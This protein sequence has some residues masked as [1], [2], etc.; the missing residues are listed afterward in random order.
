M[1]AFVVGNAVLDETILIA[2]VLQPGASILGQQISRDLGGK[3]ANQAV[4]LGRAGVETVL[5]AAVGQDA[6]SAEIRARLDQE[7]LDLRLIGV[8]VASSDF[9]IVLTSAGGE[10]AIVTTHDAAAALLPDVAVAAIS[11]AA[12][13]DL[14]VLQGNLTEATTRALLAAARLRKMTS[15]VNPSPLRPYFGGLWELVDMAF[16]NEIEAGALGHA[17]GIAAARVLSGPRAVPVVLTLGAQGAVLVVTGQDAISVA[18]APCNVVD[19]T[20]AGDCF[21]ATAI[22][23]ASLRGRPLDRLALDHAAQAA[24]ITVSRAGTASAFPSR[25]VLRAILAQR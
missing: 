21:M 25:D 7:P 16:V 10:N 4:V 19:T 17:V 11:D 22:A 23:S 15:I 13:G 3:G 6:R 24:A 12:V 2:D 5:V 20:G 18:A 14:L 8:D 9:S 1:R